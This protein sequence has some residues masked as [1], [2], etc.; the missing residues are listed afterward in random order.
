MAANQIPILDTADARRPSVLASRTGGLLSAETSSVD[1]LANVLSEAR[2][3][4]L[5]TRAAPSAELQIVAFTDP[6]DLLSYRLTP[7]AVGNTDVRVANVIVS[8]APTYFGLLERPDTA[9]CGYAG[10][11]YVLGT[12]V[13]GYRGEVTKSPITPPEGCGIVQ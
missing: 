2:R 3:S 4:Q 9:H 7:A 1:A 12:I 13:N 6:N 5:R 11:P 10:N 8:N